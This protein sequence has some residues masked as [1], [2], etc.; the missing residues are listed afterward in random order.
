MRNRY[1][2]VAAAVYDG[3]G[4]KRSTEWYQYR[5][6]ALRSRMRHS[7]VLI[8]PFR[9]RC[10]AHRTP[11]QGYHRRR[12]WHCLSTSYTIQLSF[13]DPHCYAFDSMLVY[14]CMFVVIYQVIVLAMT[15]PNTNY[16]LLFSWRQNQ[17]CCHLIQVKKYWCRCRKLKICISFILV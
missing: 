8:D 2:I 17:P 3:K 10:S 15:Y 7:H 1:E 9:V 16:L 11:R 13:L 5:D 6:Q 4:V 14:C 12:T